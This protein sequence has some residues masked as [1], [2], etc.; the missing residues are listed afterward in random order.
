MYIKKITGVD[1]DF[2]RIENE[3]LIEA[4]KDIQTF[5]KQKKSEI[6]QLKKDEKPEMIIQPGLDEA[7]RKVLQ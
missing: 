5:M 2:I 1:N 6:S 3:K 4:K 7:D